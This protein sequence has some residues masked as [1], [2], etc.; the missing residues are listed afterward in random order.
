MYYLKGYTRRDPSL[1][2]LIALSWYFWVKVQVKKLMQSNQF[3]QKLDY[4]KGL[5]SEADLGL[6]QHP[7][8]S[9]L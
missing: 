6:L 3:D 2:N 7:R 8:W 1:S 9:A 5:T 4:L